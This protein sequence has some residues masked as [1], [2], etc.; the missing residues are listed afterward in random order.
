MPSSDKPKRDVD[1]GT[2]AQRLREAREYLGF[3]QD[4]VAKY[5]GLPRSAL[6]NIENGQRRVDVIELGK[7]AKLY[8]RPLSY[9]TDEEPEHRVDPEVEHLARQAAELSS[10]DREELSRFAE[11]LRTRKQLKGG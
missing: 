2:L 8:E 5:L 3:S 1:R 4:E 6:S 10:Q 7:L 11:Y 9:F